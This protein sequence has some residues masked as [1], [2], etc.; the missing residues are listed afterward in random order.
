MCLDGQARLTGP[1][2]FSNSESFCEGKLAPTNFAQ[3][4]VLPILC[5]VHQCSTQTSLAS[6]EGSQTQH[7]QTI[8][9]RKRQDEMRCAKLGLIGEHT[10]HRSKC[11]QGW[12]DEQVLLWRTAKAKQWRDTERGATQAVTNKALR[13]T[14]AVPR[15]SQT[16]W[17]LMKA[18]MDHTSL[19]HLRG[20]RRALG[21]MGKSAY[22]LRNFCKLPCGFGFCAELYGLK[23][24]AAYTYFFHS[25]WGSRLQG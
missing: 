12:C 11:V 19:S 23:L 17:L 20:I 22:D 9:G 8:C 25:S 6:V 10:Q 16:S 18:E 3:L 13:C 21:R 5:V 15:Q 2:F 1:A 7:A 4:S 14:K 24:N